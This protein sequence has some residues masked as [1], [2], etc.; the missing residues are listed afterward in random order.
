VGTIG[1]IE[2]SVS[3]SLECKRNAPLNGLAY[4]VADPL[5]YTCG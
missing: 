1:N 5:T 3:A 2:R 4:T